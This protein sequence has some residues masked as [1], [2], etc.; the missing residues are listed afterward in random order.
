MTYEW[1]FKNSN[2]V[3]AHCTFEGKCECLINNEEPAIEDCS[4]C[5]SFEWIE[6]KEEEIEL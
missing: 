5:L 1:K 4:N 3:Y 6:M 2:Q